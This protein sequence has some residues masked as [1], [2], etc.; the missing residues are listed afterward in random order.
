MSA[1]PLPM[2]SM[3]SRVVVAFGVVMFTLASVV[4]VIGAA[5]VPSRVR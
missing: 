5:A 4:K 2:P 1:V 3:P